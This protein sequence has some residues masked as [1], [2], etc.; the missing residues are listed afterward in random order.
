AVTTGSGV[1]VIITG[2]GSDIINAGGGAN[3]V[4]STGGSDAITTG[5]GADVIV[6]G[7]SLTAADTISAGAGAD[8]L[9]VNGALVDA[10]FGGVT[11]VET[12]DLNGAATVTIGA[13]ASAA[14]IAAVTNSGDAAITV[15]AS[16]YTT[17][18]TLTGGAAADTL[19]GGAGADVLSGGAGVD[20]LNGG[21]GAD[22]Y[23]FSNVDADTDVVLTAVTDTIAGGFVS[24]SDKLDFSVAGTVANYQEVLT[25][26]ASLA[27]F[28]AAADAA[29]NGAVQ[30]YFG[31]VGADGYLAM[32]VDGTGITTL[33]KITGVTDMAFGDIT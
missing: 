12:L 7:N 6:L 18:I 2:L 22:I 31:V 9:R 17:A 20:T 33:I 8:V 28:S 21:A 11:G 5:A 19:I 10:A 25:A 23:V 15:D 14:G 30:Y 24:G 13:A 26:A 1:D 16:A 32:D 3:V 4:T 29:L 27:A